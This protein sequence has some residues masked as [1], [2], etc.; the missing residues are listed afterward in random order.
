[1]TRVPCRT[2]SPFSKVKT[3]LSWMR[4]GLGFPLTP[5]NETNDTFEFKPCQELIRHLLYL[6]ILGAATGPGF[7]ISKTSSDIAKS[8]PL[9]LLSR[10]QEV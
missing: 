2:F 9:L 1:M 7:V 8:N 10:I 5:I 4:F 6:G 3:V